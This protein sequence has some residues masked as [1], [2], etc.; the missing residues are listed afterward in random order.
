MTD[1]GDPRYHLPTGAP[2]ITPERAAKGDVLTGPPCPD[3][4]A[5]GKD[6]GPFGQPTVCRNC[7]GRGWIG[8]VNAATIAADHIRYAQIHE[9]N[10]LNKLWEG[11]SLDD[12][13]HEDGQ[14]YQIWRDMHDT[15]MGF[16]KAVGFDDEDSFGTRLRAHGYVLI[17]ARMTRHDIEALNVSLQAMAMPYADWIARNR[18]EKYLRSFERLSRVLPPIKD[19]I[20]YLEG[21]SDEEREESS[22]EGIKKMFDEW[23]GKINAA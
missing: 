20:A 21:L 23:R 6:K 1:Q 17:L 19:R 10:L 2:L 12:Q 4:K 7:R 3:C 14:T 5:T 16:R 18:V 9:V 15:Q 13:E 8:S 11:G 22:R